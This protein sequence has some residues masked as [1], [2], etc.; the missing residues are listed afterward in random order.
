M[1]PHRLLVPFLVTMGLYWGCSSDSVKNATRARNPP[2]PQPPA[3]AECPA[4]FEDCS[5]SC[6]NLRTDLDHCGACVTRCPAEKVCSDGACADGCRE[7][8]TDCSGSCVD[9]ASD[10]RHCGGCAAPCEP[11]RVCASG[12]C[13]LPAA[14]CD[15]GV[16]T[17][18]ACDGVDNDCNGVVDEGCDCEDGTKRWCAAGQGDC[19]EGEQ[20]CGFGAWGPCVPTKSPARN[21]GCDGND[22]DCDGAI[23]EGCEC[24]SGAS[25]SCGTSSYRCE[26][27]KQKCT[28]GVW[29]DCEGGVQSEEE[30]CDGIDNDCDGDIDDGCT[31]KGDSTRE[32]GTALG[33]CKPG[34]QKC[35]RGE[36]GG[37]NGGVQ[38]KPDECDGRD[39]DCDGDIDEGCECRDGAVRE[40]GKDVGTCVEGVQTCV[41]G[42][43]GSCEGDVGP[44]SE[45]CDGED[46]DCD[47]DIDEACNCVNGS[48]RQCGADVGLCVAGIQP[49]IDGAWSSC[50]QDI[51][52]D[53]EH[54][55]GEDNDCDGDIDEGCDCQHGASRWCRAGQGACEDGT[56]TCDQG[57]WGRCNSIQSPAAELC[58]DVDNDCDGIV[59]DGFNL[60]E[61]CPSAGGCPQSRACTPDGMSSVCSDDPRLFASEYCDGVDNDCNGLVDSIIADG[62]VQSLC[63][64][65]AHTL[66]IG[67]AVNASVAGDRNLCARTACGGD[68]PRHLRVDATCY[69]VCQT[70]ADPDGDGWGWENG[71]SCIVEDSPRGRAARPC[72]GETAP[73]GMAMSYCL[74]CSGPGELPFAM[75]QS[76][77]QFDLR[78][79]GRGEAWLR[80]EYSYYATGAAWIPINLWFDT[81]GTRRKHLPLVNVGD[82]PVNHATKLFR[83]EEACFAAS[84][85]FG[86]ACA[87]NGQQC[88]HC[89]PDEVCGAIAECGAY[90]LSQAWLQVAA[91]FCARGS[92]DQAGTVT[93]HQV[94]LVEPN[95]EN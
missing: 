5:G 33:P 79:F 40:C 94:E 86:S 85:V 63:T 71:A 39:N 38:P 27:G 58:D 6:A 31:C 34:T 8:L 60:S 50:V 26:L 28:D 21:D 17:D 42:A 51:G 35:V 15:G 62:V 68:R 13:A 80:V 55:D 65:G 41:A 57:S 53:A 23:D 73:L 12:T 61:L 36:W 25:R 20:T 43:W 11:G 70:N 64:C 18:E 76:L 66:T 84:S 54:C 7:G 46:N 93:L 81:G 88:A 91:E 67:R 89:G 72:D 45:H 56:Q 37:C 49:C 44:D 9:L 95:C 47:G 22:N 1:S 82:P 3:Q 69:V 83:I 77:P 74:A 92:G 90:D 2:P 78:T 52:P 14:L 48:T 29:G 4:T 24:Q 16:A 32:C 87:G 75:C 19:Y 59:D 30:S 10:E